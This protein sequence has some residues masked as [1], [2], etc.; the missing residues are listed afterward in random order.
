MGKGMFVIQILPGESTLK[1]VIQAANNLLFKSS[2]SNNLLMR[3]C[4]TKIGKAMFTDVMLNSVTR[5]SLVCWKYRRQTVG[6]PFKTKSRIWFR[7]MIG[8]GCGFR[9]GSGFGWAF[10]F[11]VDL[12]LDVGFRFAAE[13]HLGLNL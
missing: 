11:G 13:L 2:T 7:S 4:S 1:L 9:A 3:L 8:S 6:I 5:D 10:G 12:G